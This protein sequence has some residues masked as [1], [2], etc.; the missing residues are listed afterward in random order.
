MWLASTIVAQ[1]E[2]AFHLLGTLVVKE[3]VVA[4]AI[5]TTVL[6][7]ICTPRSNGNF[8]IEW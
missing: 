3:T 1:S 4:I 7:L 5:N 6:Y 2:Q 8:G